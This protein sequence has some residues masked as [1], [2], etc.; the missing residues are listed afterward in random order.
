MSKSIGSALTQNGWVDFTFDLSDYAGDNIWLVL[1]NDANGGENVAG[2]GAALG[3][4]R[5][6]L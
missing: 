5:I 2:L 1:T 4:P 3:V 6:T